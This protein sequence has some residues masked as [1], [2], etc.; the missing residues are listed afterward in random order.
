MK[1]ILSIMIA[2]IT[3]LTVCAYAEGGQLSRTTGLP[4]DKTEYKAMAVQ[5]DNTPAARPQLNMFQADVIYE[6]EIWDGGYTRYTAIF[7][8]EIPDLV[9]ANRSARIMH[10]DAALDWTANFV[11]YGYQDAPGS[12]VREYL[13][14]VKHY[15]L[16]NGMTDSKN[17]Y[18]DTSR[19]APYNAIA[20]LKQMYD[21]AEAIDPAEVH[22][23]LVF[24]AENPT[25]KG[26]A[27]SAFS[28]PYNPR[29]KYEAS[30]KYDASTDTYR[31]YYMG[32]AQRDG[33]TG[34]YFD[35]KNVIV[36]TAE[37]SWSYGDASAPLVEL[38]GSNK[39]DY[40]IGGQHF[41]GT[42]T[43]SGADSSTVYLDDEGNVVNFKPG[44][45]FIQVIK[46]AVELVIEG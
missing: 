29:I 15:G 6:M 27:V 44:K 34:A 13:D 21:S 20:K 30:W 12:S 3:L 2:V 10:V 32:E 19:K 31:R 45:T 1:R 8:D 18:R 7:N 24:S 11:F 28:I 16:F 9:E 17:F 46:P 43:R 41:T 33:A 26:E 14:S 5:F 37:Y 22:T 40:F 39:C 23:P 35:A 4:T 42:W 25:V 38:F 36:M